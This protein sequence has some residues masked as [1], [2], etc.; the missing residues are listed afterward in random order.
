MTLVNEMY[1]AILLDR[2]SAGP[3][4]IAC[5]EG[6]TSIEDLG[7]LLLDVVALSLAFSPV[8]AV[9]RVTRRADSSVRR[10]CRRIPE[11]RGI[12]AGRCRRVSARGIARAIQQKSLPSW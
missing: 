2:A 6:G 8:I 1:F 4:V 11:H 3:M 10:R 9:A 7:Q 12:E 5:S